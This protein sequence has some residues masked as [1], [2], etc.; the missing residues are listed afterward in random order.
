MARDGDHADLAEA[1]DFIDP[2]ALDYQT[3]VGVGMALKESGLSC[4][5]WDSWSR[6]D[7][8]RYHEGECAKK[9]AGFGHGGGSPLGSGTVAKMAREAGWEPSGEGRGQALAWDGVISGPMLDPSWV[10]PAEVTPSDKSGAQQL[11]EYL[12]AL[13]EPEDYVGYCMESCERDGRFVPANSGCY[14][15]TCGDI[16]RD[17]D[18]YGD[19]STALGGYDIEAGAW[20]R[21]NPLDGK[22]VRNVDVAEYRYALVE[23]DAVSREQQLSIIRALR[24]PCAA[25]VDSGRKSIHAVVRVEAGT[26]DEYRRRVD[27]LYRVCNENG[28]EVDGQNKNPSRLSRMPGVT[29]GESIQS[30]VSGPCGCATWDEWLDWVQSESDNLP[31]DSHADWDEPIRLAPP[32]IGTE[33]AGILRQG[34]KMVLAGPSKAGKSFALIDLAEAICCGGRWLGYPC[35]E[36]PVYYVNL[37]IADESFRNRQHMVWDDRERQGDVGSGLKSVKDNFYR[38]DLRGHAAELSQ[39]APTIVRRILKRG[40]RGTFK[41]VVIDPIYKVNGG[42]ENDARAISQFTNQL[43]RISQ[44]CGCAVIYAH[45]HAKGQMGQRKSMDRMSGSGVFARDADSIL[46]LTELEVPDGERGRIGDATAWRM[47]ATLREFRSPDPIDLLFEFPRFYRDA[48]GLLSR[49]EV[50]GADPLKAVNDRRRERALRDR[51]GRVSAMRSAMAAC[52][53]AGEVPTRQRVLERINEGRDEADR[54]TFTQLLHWTRAKAEWSPIRCRDKAGGFAL[55]DV[56]AE[57]AA[58]LEGLPGA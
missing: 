24:L 19:V 25:I 57:M 3:W 51:E 38:L 56:E 32:L 18:R 21:F 45:H 23:S 50:E 35:A 28:L 43:D 49:F 4:D 11:S 47:T 5:V 7:P 54:V 58:S 6:R 14:T 37:E 34:Q 13:F 8:T 31:E 12:Q 52:E 41:A 26:Y 27:A 22:G 2:A 16:L 15:R 29:R 53:A 48:D 40:P 42:D 30:L 39:L 1:L 9:W 10:E 55:Y 44:E 17:L 36:G 46:D 20:V 33:D